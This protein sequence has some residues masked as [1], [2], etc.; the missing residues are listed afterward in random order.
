MKSV[1]L[2]HIAPQAHLHLA[3]VA[4]IVIAVVAIAASFFFNRKRS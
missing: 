3:D 2:A 1:V 4:L